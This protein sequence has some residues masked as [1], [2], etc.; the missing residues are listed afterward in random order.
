MAGG[1]GVAKSEAGGGEMMN[2]A[3]ARK[4]T[5]NPAQ[6]PATENMMGGGMSGGMMAAV[7]NITPNANPNNRYANTEN[8]SLVLGVMRG[9]KKANERVKPTPATK[10]DVNL[11]AL[12]KAAQARS[13]EEIVDHLTLR[14]LSLPLDQQARGALVN[15]VRKNLK[16]EKIDY[17][18]PETEQVLR[19]LTHLIM[20]TP[21]YQLG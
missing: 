1:A 5:P 20:S 13:P 11:T 12:V 7:P 4:T 3:A 17:S 15:F 16:S 6:T 18:A 9:V 21:A 8:Y 2:A 19:E 10:A 14:F